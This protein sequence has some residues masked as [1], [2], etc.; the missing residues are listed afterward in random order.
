MIY[1]KN[2]NDIVKTMLNLRHGHGTEYTDL[3]N[4]YNKLVDF[5]KGM[6]VK[7][8]Y[9]LLYSIALRTLSLSTSQSL[10]S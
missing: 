10:Q 5:N 3:H 8:F 9:L 2:K 4:R 6:N 7:G 1:E